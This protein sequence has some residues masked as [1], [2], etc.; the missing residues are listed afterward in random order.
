MAPLAGTHRSYWLQRHWVPLS[1]SPM[2]PFE[3][4]HWRS[5]GTNGPFEWR[6]W[7]SSA[8]LAPMI[9]LSVGAIGAIGANGGTIVAN[10]FTKLIL[11]PESEHCTLTQSI[12]RYTYTQYT[13]TQ[14]T[15][16]IHYTTMCIVVCVYNCLCVNLLR[17]QL[18]VCTLYNLSVCTVVCTMFCVY[19]FLCVHF[20]EFTLCVWLYVCA[21]VRFYAHTIAYTNNTTVFLTLSII[22]RIPADN[23]YIL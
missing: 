5:L 8:P 22:V 4:R 12:I 7:R 13:Q 9:K 10:N 21:I 18:H 17:V 1:I 6:H 2:A 15:Q 16:Y 23:S 19:N 3:W 20:S 14:T 11:L